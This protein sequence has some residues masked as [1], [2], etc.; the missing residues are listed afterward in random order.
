MGNGEKNGSAVLFGNG[1]FAASIAAYL[2]H[3][4]EYEVV[5][6]TVDRD[7]ITEPTLLGRPVVP[8]EEVEEHFP[9]DEHGML[10]SL[11]YRRMNRLRAEKC[12]QAKAKGYPL[13]SYISSKASLG[14][15]VEIGENCF[16]VGNSLIEPFVRIGDNVY[17]NSGCH[18]GHHTVIHDHCYLAAHVA[19]AGV[20]TIGAYSFLG[21]NAAVRN[22]ITIAKESVVGAG[23][24]VV[25]DTREGGVY[26]GNPGR[27][28]PHSSDKLP[29][30]AF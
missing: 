1:D 8:F 5:A 9:P 24:V 30:D 11:G 7:H 25:K 15:G 14:A 2:A 10:V 26:V 22:G 3:D 29:D 19:V 27:L 17:I 16:I 12:A 28:L 18:I 20:V 6:F 23:S 13:L 21:I 4:S